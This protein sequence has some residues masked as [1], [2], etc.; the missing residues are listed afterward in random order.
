MPTKCL[1]I[2]C[3]KKTPLS[4]WT[5]VW[6][7]IWLLHCSLASMPEEPSS[8]QAAGKMHHLTADFSEMSTV[9]K[10]TEEPTRQLDTGR[11]LGRYFVKTSASAGCE[12]MSGSCTVAPFYLELWHLEFLITWANNDS[13]HVIYIISYSDFSKFGVTWFILLHSLFKF[14]INWFNCIGS[15]A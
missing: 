10:R 12:R 2:L 11:T 14:D 8:V 6:Q 13:L 3:T 15:V 9:D 7:L 1:F 5:I 4:L